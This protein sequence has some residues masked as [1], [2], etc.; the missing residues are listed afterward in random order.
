MADDS[1][2]VETYV[3][4]LTIEGIKK[5]AFP[6][7]THLA[8]LPRQTHFTTLAST[9]LLSLHAPMTTAVQQYIVFCAD[10]SGRDGFAHG[11]ELER[12]AAKKKLS[13]TATIP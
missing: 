8:N 3:A 13:H 2:D 10:S 11:T 6:L 1:S 4:M 9:T 12:V 7:L 5:R